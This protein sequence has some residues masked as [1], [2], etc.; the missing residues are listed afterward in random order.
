MRRTRQIQ[1]ITH[2]NIGTSICADVPHNGDV[3]RRRCGAVGETSAL[4]GAFGI[5]A[6]AEPRLIGTEI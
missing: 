5:S 1:G 2:L 4:A 6:V 3:P